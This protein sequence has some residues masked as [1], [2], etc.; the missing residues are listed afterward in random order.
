[1]KQ[2]LSFEHQWALKDHDNFWANSSLHTGSDKPQHQLEHLLQTDK[3]KKP[4]MM[5]LLY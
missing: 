2:T 5:Y 1:M 3:Q 4:S